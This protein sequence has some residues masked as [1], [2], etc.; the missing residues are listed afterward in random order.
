MGGLLVE[1]SNGSVDGILVLL[2]PVTDVVTDGTGV[3]VKFEV[4]ISLS[5]GL[6]ASLAE[7]VG[8]AHVVLVELVLEGLVRGLGEHT[9]F[10]E[11]G[12][13]THWLFDQVKSSGQIHTEI[14]GFP[15]NTF[16]L[17][18]F[19]F[20][21]EHVVIEELLELLVSVVDAKLLEGVEVENFET[22]NIEDT[23][24]VVSGEGGGE[25]IV[26]LDTEPVE[27]SGEDG[28]GE[29]TLGVMDL[30]D[31][32][33]LGDE[34]SS[35]LDSG[36]ANV[37][38]EL[39]GVETEEEAALVG[40]FSSIGLS[41][42]F[43]LLVSE[44]H[45]HVVEDGSGDL[46]DTVDL[47]LSEAK[48]VEG[49]VGKKKFFTIIEV[50]DNDDTLGDGGVV[51]GVSGDKELLGKSG[52]LVGDDL[53]EDM[54]VSLT[55]ELEGDSRL[56]EK[57]GL[58]I[59][60]GELARSAEVNSDEFTESRRVI[61]SGG[62]GVT[63]GFEGRVGRDNLVFEGHV[64]GRLGTLAV[65]GS[66]STSGS[67][68]GE[69][70]DDL[71]GVDGL[72]GTRLTSNKHRLVFSVGQHLLVGSISDGVQ[73]RGHFVSLT[74]TVGVD[75][76]HSVHGEHLVGVNS[77]AEKTR[78]GVD[79]ELSVSRSE[80]V[81]DRGFVEVSQ[82]GHVFTLVVLGRVAFHNIFL[83]DLVNFFVVVSDELGHTALGLGPFTSGVTHIGILG[84]GDPDGLGATDLLSQ[85]DLLGHDLHLFL[86]GHSE[87]RGRILEYAQ[88]QRHFRW[89]LSTFLKR[90]Y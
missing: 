23:N 48:N 28:L 24:E 86:L 54:V 67:D 74:A 2:E 75:T 19:L 29:G 31:G 34:L 81:E 40:V 70:L 39:R 65:A 52:D 89:F 82:V 37:L 3:V 4:D 63:E 49:F 45:V 72:T 21:D 55:A 13:D 9:F 73:V 25:G 87:V 53:V 17:V 30:V 84:S 56:F 22:S 47:F 90:K 11:N 10:F 20:E 68:E 8:L 6:G 58:N 43:S 59:T 69:V 35:D 27:E 57:I 64:L 33:T 77:D 51:I 85:S 26:D 1:S 16:L 83:L 79:K 71:L 80:N 7:G 41:L 15:V 42:F 78:I 88:V 18:G 38:Q 76:V 46:V 5:L 62:L 36:V 60:T 66:G 14:D 61:V 50:L 44:L 32:L 12:E